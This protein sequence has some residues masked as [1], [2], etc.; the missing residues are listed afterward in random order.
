M[1]EEVKIMIH[2]IHAADLHLDTPFA[3]LKHLPE[4]YYE[5]IRQSTF[6]SFERLVQD[7]IDKA[8]DF[9]VLAG[10]IFDESVRS[11][12]AQLFFKDEMKKLERS[13]I[14][15]YLIHGNHD[16]LIEGEDYFSLPGNVTTF[17]SE[18]TSA[19]LTTSSGEKVAVTSFSYDRKWITESKLNDYPKKFSHV[20]YHIGLLHGYFESSQEK[21]DHYAPFTRE[22]IQKLQYD[23][24]ALGHI[25][26]GQKVLSQPASYYSGSLQGKHRNEEGEK[27]YLEVRINPFNVDVTFQPVQEIQWRTLAI[28]LHSATRLE[29]LAQAIYE[30]VNEELVINKKY[31]LT[32]DLEID[33]NFSQD[34]L[35]RIQNDD[36]LQTL[37]IMLE[38]TSIWLNS[39]R[40]TENE[41]IEGHSLQKNHPENFERALHEVKSEEV[42][43]KVTADFFEKNN[44]GQLVDERDEEYRSYIMEQA[45]HLLGKEGK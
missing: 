27:G 26:R 19:F 43:N 24:L 23:Y 34:L 8:V 32:L 35:T 31:I 21:H 10:D 6:N 40:L 11:V 18:I 38:E 5:T 12:E 9:I 41:R 33:S 15:V 42:F 44:N 16:P 28:A 36:L 4:K 17:P 14:P 1:R 39:I 3:G 7:A 30:E 20:D 37:R 2:F 13:K 29:E 22:M 45:L 25:H